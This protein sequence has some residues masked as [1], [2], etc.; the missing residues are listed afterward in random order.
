M[1]CVSV[2][3][4]KTKCLEYLKFRS[5]V[6]IEMCHNLISDCVIMNYFS[7]VCQYC[8]HSGRIFRKKLVWN[9][10]RNLRFKSN[11]KNSWKKLDSINKSSWNEI[12]HWNSGETIFSSKKCSFEEKMFIWFKWFKVKNIYLLEEYVLLEQKDLSKAKKCKFQ[13]NS[14]ISKK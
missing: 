8:V 3:E 11:G 12:L 2:F 1:A 13:E 6:E 14:L 5:F 9:R 7:I 10:N 4:F